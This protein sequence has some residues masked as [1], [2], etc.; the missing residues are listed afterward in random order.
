MFNTVIMISIVMIALM[1][2]STAFTAWPMASRY[3]ISAKGRVLDKKCSRPY[4]RH[5]MVIEIAEFGGVDEEEDEEENENANKEIAIKPKK[6]TLGYEGSYKPG[7]VVRVAKSI[8]IFSVKEYSKDGFDIKDFVGTVSALKL[9]GRKFK[10]VCSA[11]TP[12][13][14]AFKPD[15][16]GIPPGMFKATFMLHFAADELELIKAAPPVSVED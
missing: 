11:I 7:D 3:K 8:K 9:Y 4:T 14:V 5:D 1:N 10:T 12:I 6:K 16:E 13:V 15:E 2:L